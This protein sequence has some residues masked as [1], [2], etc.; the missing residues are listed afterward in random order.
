[1][2]LSLMFLSSGAFAYGIGYSTHPMLTRT[3]LLTAEM[4]G[5]VKDGKGVGAQARYTHQLRPEV[6]LD[7]GVGISGGERSKRAFIG[8][9]YEFLP[10][11]IKKT[12]NLN[13]DQNI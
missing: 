10:D 4:T 3:G 1:M 9:D 5:I 7:T 6:S 13:N 12:G 11:Y 8:A 2:A